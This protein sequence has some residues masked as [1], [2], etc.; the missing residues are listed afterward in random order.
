MMSV[1]SSRLPGQISSTDRR[2]GFTLIELMVVVAI[3]GMLVAL[4]LPAVQQAREAARRAQCRSQ[5][6]QMALAIHNHESTYQKLPSGGWGWQWIG[7]PD[8]GV[9]VRQPGGWIYQIL[10]QIEQTAYRQL[11]SGQPD[12]QRRII[13]GDLTQAN[14]S[15]LR[16]PSRPSPNLPAS[17]PSFPWINCELRPNMGRTDYAIN[18]GDNFSTVTGGPTSLAEGDDPNYAWPDT[19]Q[20]NG[21]CYL[22]SHLGWRD[23]LD[24]MSNVYLVGEKR[25][26]T[27]HYGDATDQGY[28]EAPFCGADIDVMRW[29]DLPPL[30]D[31]VAIETTAFGGAHTGIVQM[32]LCDGS[33]RSISL[34][35]DAVIHRRLG[36]RNDQQP[37]SLDGP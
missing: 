35:I 28:D 27:A 14:L 22:R 5:L 32:A 21:V 13:L 31:S 12:A 36:N 19:S 37:A 3:I 1:R 16:C 30:Q 33:V 7:E 24:G 18:A 34:N 4:L 17:N 6:K 29:T 20:M 11:G 2:P 23:V 25:V 8:R 9:D 10:P 26:S 15:I